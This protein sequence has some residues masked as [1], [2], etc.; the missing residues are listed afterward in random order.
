[1][2]KPKRHDVQIRIRDIGD[3]PL[4]LFLLGIAQRP[5]ELGN[6]RF[7]SWSDLMRMMDTIGHKRLGGQVRAEL[8]KTRE[9][10]IANIAVPETWFADMLV[11]DIFE[12]LVRLT[13]TAN[14]SDGLK[15]AFQRSKRHLGVQV[16]RSASP[17]A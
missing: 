4:Q 13:K 6:V 1:M 3:K 9:C 16:T 11:G 8:E 17:D 12:W 5:T 2:A 7:L 14:Q 15:R 10:K